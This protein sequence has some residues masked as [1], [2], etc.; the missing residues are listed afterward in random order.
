MNKIKPLSLGILQNKKS[1]IISTEESLKDV[2]PMNWSE[3]V[4]SVEKK[5]LID[6][7]PVESIEKSLKEIKEFKD[8]KRKFKTLEESQKM[9]ADWIEDMEDE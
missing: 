6:C 4:L 5:V 9:W 1:T 2:V 3:E 8:G 7:T